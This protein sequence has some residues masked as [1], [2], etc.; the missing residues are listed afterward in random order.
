MITRWIPAISI[1]S[2]QNQACETKVALVTNP[3][4]GTAQAVRFRDAKYRATKACLHR[5][6]EKRDHTA[7]KDSRIGSSRSET[8]TGRYKKTRR[9]AKGTPPGQMVDSPPPLGGGVKLNW[10]SYSSCNQHQLPLEL[11]PQHLGS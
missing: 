8:K 4:S 9:H 2:R 7:R 6:T 5:S 10:I 11:L 3:L 1:K